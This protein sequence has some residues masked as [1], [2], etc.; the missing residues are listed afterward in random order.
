MKCNEMKRMTRNG[1]EMKEMREVKE[2]KE[3]RKY[4][5]L[6]TST[7]FAHSFMSVCELKLSDSRSHYLS[8]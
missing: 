6:L 7:A 1:I 5:T 4:R 3:M 2:M 8:R